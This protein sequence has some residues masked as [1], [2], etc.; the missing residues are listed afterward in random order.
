M[1]VMVESCD[2]FK[3]L[4]NIIVNRDLSCHYLGSEQ[5]HDLI[6]SGVELGL[7]MPCHRKLGLALRA[8]HDL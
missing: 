7:K 6:E 1:I 2:G 5:G 3:Q 8:V 4:T